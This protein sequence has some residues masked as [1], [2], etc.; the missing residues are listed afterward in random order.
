MIFFLI[1]QE[2]ASINAVWWS[3]IWA[4]GKDRGDW[5]GGKRTKGKDTQIAPRIAFDGH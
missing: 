1:W 2:S 5:K 4:I 3:E